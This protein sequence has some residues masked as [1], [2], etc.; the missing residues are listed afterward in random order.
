ME[1]EFARREAQRIEEERLENMERER[2]EAERLEGE[3]IVEVECLERDIE[4]QLRLEK[5]STSI[6][7]VVSANTL[8]RAEEGREGRATDRRLV[9]Q[10]AG[11]KWKGVA[12]ARSVVN[13]TRSATV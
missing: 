11:R 8:R 13:T 5:E 10:I 9:N 1:E 4:E 7:Q 12:S 2:L 3:R 6:S